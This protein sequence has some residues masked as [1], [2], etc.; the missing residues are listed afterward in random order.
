MPKDKVKLL[1]LISLLFICWG[2]YN[3]SKAIYT[4]LAW[5]KTNGIVV[6]ILQHTFSCGKGVSRCYT[7]LAGF[8]VNKDYYTVES[9]SK[10][11]HNEPKHLNGI[12]VD[13]YYPQ[14]Q[15]ESAIMGGD[16]GPGDGGTNL[17]FVGLIM[18]VIWFFMRNSNA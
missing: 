11:S 14:G 5:E 13:V 16:Y 18:L 3:V 15:P 10:Y 7:L 4:S 12:K 1:L 17:L 6:D 9:D 2:G 8:H